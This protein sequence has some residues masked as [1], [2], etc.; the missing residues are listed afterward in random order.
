[1]KLKLEKPNELERDPVLNFK[2]KLTKEEERKWLRDNQ[3]NP[4]KPVR[5]KTE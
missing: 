4:G 5:P 1:M 2:G 3:N